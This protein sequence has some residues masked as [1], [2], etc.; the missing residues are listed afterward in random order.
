M[1]P[2]IQ[3]LELLQQEYPEVN[4]FTNEVPEEF[5]TLP[6]LPVGRVVE[7]DMN[8]HAYASADPNLYTTHLQLDMWV[9]DMHD[10]SKYYMV[11]DKTMRAD[12]VQCSYSEQT[13][14][15][16]LAGSRRIIKRYDIT[17]RVV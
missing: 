11:L 2:I 3:V 1:M 10:I 17:N 12:N 5:Q 13:Y 16:D 7:L 4:W 15:P 9:N 8:Y 6:N 14:D